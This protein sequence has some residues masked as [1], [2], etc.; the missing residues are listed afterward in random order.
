MDSE[1]NVETPHFTSQERHD[2]HFLE[3]EHG[4]TSGRVRVKHRRSKT[5][6]KE[7]IIIKNINYYHNY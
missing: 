7:A 1:I 2:D 3:H 4:N 6:Y 5:S